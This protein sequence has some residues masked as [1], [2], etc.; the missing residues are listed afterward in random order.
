VTGEGTDNVDVIRVDKKLT[1]LRPGRSFSRFQGT[2]L[3]PLTR[4]FAN[5]RLLPAALRTGHYP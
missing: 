2:R 3:E 4:E 5:A 1:D